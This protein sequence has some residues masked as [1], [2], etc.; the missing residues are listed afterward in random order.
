MHCA[1]SLPVVAQKRMQY[2]GQAKAAP[3]LHC[4]IGGPAHVQQIFLHGEAVTRRCA[5]Y[6]QRAP[7]LCP[8]LGALGHA[9]R[10][11]EKAAFH[12]LVDAA[13]LECSAGVW[14]GGFTSVPKCLGISRKSTLRN[15]VGPTY[16]VMHKKT[17]AGVEMCEQ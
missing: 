6:E 16:N 14:D 5:S 8:N 7:E 2:C 9:Q 12:E 17:C 10:G 1:R 4:A 13:T 3:E 11:H 15:P